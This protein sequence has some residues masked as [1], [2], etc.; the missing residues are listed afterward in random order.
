MG[1]INRTVVAAR[2][3][4]PLALLLGFAAC[5]VDDFIPT[6]TLVD[7]TPTSTP[8]PYVGNWFGTTSQS[9]P[10]S[11]AIDGTGMTSLATGF[12]IG[13]PE[14]CVLDGSMDIDLVP[15]EQVSGNQISFTDSGGIID[16]VF[17]GTFSSSSAA[18]GELTVTS[19]PFTAP[20]DG[21]SATITWTANKS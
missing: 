13:E 14:T 19:T 2:F 4:A 9:R 1:R 6:D 17:Q 7:P 15:P 12:R 5:G 3:C 16:T 20:C 21:L 18:S 10:I 8:S 11:F